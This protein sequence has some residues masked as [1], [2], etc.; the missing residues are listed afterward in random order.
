VQVGVTKCF[1]ELVHP[2]PSRVPSRLAAPPAHLS[3][4]GVMK[5]IL[6]SSSFVDVATMTFVPDP[7]ATTT[8][9]SVP[10]GG[11]FSM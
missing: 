7:F 3:Y 6:T 1:Q 8:S 4:I 11:M 2:L 5:I 9:G 10:A